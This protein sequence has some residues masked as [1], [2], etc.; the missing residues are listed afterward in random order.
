MRD[1]IETMLLRDQAQEVIYFETV[2]E[3]LIH[4]VKSE[5]EREQ[6]RDHLHI[7]IDEKEHK[8]HIEYD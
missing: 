1:F 3:E 4:K 6:H 7:I 5:Q 8:F 2:E